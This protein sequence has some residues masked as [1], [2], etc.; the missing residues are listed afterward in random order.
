MII[1]FEEIKL[2]TVE[3]KLTVFPP[4]LLHT[5]IDSQRSLGI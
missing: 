3:E 4:A 1:K 5:L 2:C